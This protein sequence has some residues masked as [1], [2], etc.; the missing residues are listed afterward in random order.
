MPVCPYC[1]LDVETDEEIDEI[2]QAKLDGEN[3]CPFCEVP[4]PEDIFDAVLENPADDT[5]P[6]DFLEKPFTLDE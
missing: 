2:E 1:S 5:L 3:E 4:F 6:D